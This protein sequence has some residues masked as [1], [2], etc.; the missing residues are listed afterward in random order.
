[1][2]AIARET[3]RAGLVVL[4]LKERLEKKV[5]L[6]E[7][8]MAVEKAAQKLRRT[9]EIF[10]RQLIILKGD[11]NGKSEISAKNQTPAR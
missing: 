6:S 11:E 2:E 9:C 5:P 4:M 1:M 7:K 8:L 10:E 3:I